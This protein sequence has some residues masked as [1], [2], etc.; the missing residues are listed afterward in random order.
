MFGEHR[1]G[2]TEVGRLFVFTG[3]PSG[4]PLPYP[5]PT[6]FYSQHAAGVLRQYLLSGNPILLVLRMDK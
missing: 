1:Y 4:Q 3:Y 6:V 5:A 2:A